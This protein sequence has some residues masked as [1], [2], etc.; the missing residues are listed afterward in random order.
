MELFVNNGQPG[1]R[2]TKETHRKEIQGDI[3]LRTKTYLS[4]IFSFQSGKL[5][6]RW[7]PGFGTYLGRLTSEFLLV[8][9][10]GDV[11]QGQ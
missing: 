10:K 6:V 9:T 11:P 2:I 3:Y 1:M 4:L 8:A 5:T 7:E